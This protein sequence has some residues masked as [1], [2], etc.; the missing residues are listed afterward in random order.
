MKRKLNCVLLIDDYKADNFLHKMIL[1][2][3]DIANKVVAVESGPEALAYLQSS[4]NGAYPQPDLIFLDLNMPGMDGWE[5]LDAY[6]Q[7]DKQQQGRIVMVMLT[8]SANPDHIEKANRLPLV[9]GFKGKP[10]TQEILD[11]VLNN[12]FADWL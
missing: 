7:L 1:D 11:E 9:T 8:T 12:H 5:F 3:A 2:R 6:E 10:L 4:E